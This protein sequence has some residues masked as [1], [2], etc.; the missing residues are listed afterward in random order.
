MRQSRRWVLAPRWHARI[1]GD[2]SV[3]DGQ[4]TL[5]ARA[6]AF[7]PQAAAE[8]LV[9]TDPAR[10]D[11]HHQEPRAGDA[12]IGSACLPAG[13]DLDFASACPDLDDLAAN[14][15]FDYNRRVCRPVVGEVE[16]HRQTEPVA[17]RLG[18]A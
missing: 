16:A 3:P 10:Y 9:E 6:L 5:E 13:R 2:S 11:G 12:H 7:D 15:E 8:G 17:L 1:V 14:L 4:E 18:I